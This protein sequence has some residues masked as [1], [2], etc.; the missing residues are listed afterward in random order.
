[1]RGS[2]FSNIGALSS[3]VLFNNV[4]YVS[5]I[6]SIVANDE[7]YFSTL[8]VFNVPMSRWQFG[9]FIHGAP[10]SVNDGNGV[11]FLMEP[12]R[13]NKWL[14]NR[15]FFGTSPGSSEVVTSNA[16]ASPDG[17]TA[18]TEDNVAF[19]NY[20]SYQ[21]MI[22]PANTQIVGT[23]YQ[24]R[25]TGTGNG[26]P[27]LSNGD[28]SSAASVAT[29][30]TTTY[31]RLELQVNMLVRTD[32]LYIPEDGRSTWGGTDQA[33]DAAC[34]LVQVEAGYWPTSPIDTLGTPVTRPQDLLSY[35]STEYP[36]EFLSTGFVFEFA[37]DCSSTEFL[38]EG[39]SWV[40]MSVSWM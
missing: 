24:R 20:G 10:R 22:Y 29:A 36:K 14:Y 25:V 38:A 1:M 11:C 8:M 40:F 5:L 28:V 17:L 27:G 16:C 21:V 35:S 30:L 9:I 2:V 13:T 6:D 23:S 12:S 34:D 7:K 32:L 19:G 39:G 37:P 33:L 4:L 31:Q 15:S 3:T 26:K 18:G